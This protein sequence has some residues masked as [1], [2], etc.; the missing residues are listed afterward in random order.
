MGCCATEATEVS[1]DRV[2]EKMAFFVRAWQYSLN[3]FQLAGVA[4]E[5]LNVRI[6]NNECGVA[7]CR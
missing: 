1:P 2:N 4:G 5:I 7:A 3:G 6:G